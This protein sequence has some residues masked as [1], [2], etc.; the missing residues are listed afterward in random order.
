[1]SRSAH[2]QIVTSVLTFFSVSNVGHVS[3]M[4]L[5]FRM[6]RANTRCVAKTQIRSTLFAIPST[7]FGCMILCKSTML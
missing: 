4:I 7:S 3:V 2:H 6:D 5:H 1:M